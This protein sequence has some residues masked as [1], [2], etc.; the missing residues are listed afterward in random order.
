LS[1]S[2]VP[3][4]FFSVATA[5][6]RGC[7]RLHAH[8]TLG[9]VA[10]AIPLVLV[11]AIVGARASLARAATALLVG[12]S[13]VAMVA[14]AVAAAAVPA[15]RVVPRSTLAA[16]LAMARSSA[17]VGRL[18]VLGMAYQRAGTVVVALFVGPAASGWFSTAGRVA[19]ASETGHVALFS[20]AYPAMAEGG[21]AH[22]RLRWS[23]R[24]CVVGGLV[25]TGLL[26]AGGPFLVARLYGA[27][28]APAGRA[29]QV[30]ALGVVAS[31]VA[32][33]QSLLLLGAHRERAVGRVLALSLATL[34]VALSVLVPVFGW[35]GACWA[36]VAA[37]W[38]QAGLMGRARRRWLS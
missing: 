3:S 38:V 32:T 35:I 8:A 5:M 25:V 10:T 12:Q 37:D 14:W 22:D 34:L 6:L 33:Y 7:G 15:M 36:S 31:T 4:A 18:G 17:T 23:W 2:L 28:F 27:L 19:D 24:A 11:G 30:L 1:L 21:G 9:V 20:A 29:L 13:L 26:L 16:T